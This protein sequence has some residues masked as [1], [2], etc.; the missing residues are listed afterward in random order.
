MDMFIRLGS[1]GGAAVMLQERLTAHGIK[2][3]LTGFADRPTMD[4]VER[5]QET[6]GIKER[7]C[8]ASETW[9]ALEAEP[10]AKKP[11]AKRGAEAV[12]E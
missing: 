11:A 3:H 1:I 8:V 10:V 4:A 2:T 9:T 5:F 6:H 7:G 12:A